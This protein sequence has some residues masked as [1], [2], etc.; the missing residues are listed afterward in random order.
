[1]P[2]ASYWHVLPFFFAIHEINQNPR[3]LPNI[4]LGY[5]IYENYLNERITYEAMI[6]LLSMGQKTVPNYR[7]GR[8]KGLLAVLEETD[9]ELFQYVAA[10]LGTY[11][12][13]Q[14]NYG[15]IS[16]IS[17]HKY[18]FPFS[19]RMGPRQEPPHLVIVKLLL[20]FQWTW[21][22]L[23]APDNENGEKFRKTF[24]PAA[25]KQGVCVAFS[26]SIPVL[27]LERKKD[28]LSYLRK[29]KVNAIVSQLDMSTVTTL[30]V[31]IRIMDRREKLAVGKV[32]I[33]T[34][35]SDLNA[36]WLYRIV[37]LQHKHAFL[38]FVIRTKTR[39][40]YD[41]AISDFFAFEMFAQSAFQCS[42][43]S[44]VLSRKVWERCTEKE[45][46]G[47]LPPDLVAKILSEDAYSIRNAVQ[48][49][50]RTLSAAY[51]SQLGQERRQVGHHPAPQPWQ[52]HPF[53]KIFQVSNFSADGGYLEKD[54]NPAASFDIIQ[55]AVLPNKSTSGVKVGSVE[56][57]ASSEVKISVDQNAII[58]PT[59]FN[60]KVPLSRCTESCHPG[61]T[62]LT[63]EGAPIC[64]Y[65]CSRCVEGTFSMQEDAAHCK[66]C[67]DDQH[68]N[69]KRDQCDP[70]V[71]SFLSYG[72]TLGLILAISAFILSLTTGFVLYIFIKYRETPIVK[73]NN[74]DLTYILLVSLLLSFL[75]SLL[76]IGHP[77]KI[78]CLLRQTTF[79]IVFSVAVSSLL[80]KTIMVVVA[81]L[82]TK[83]GSR[84]RKWLG[85]HLANSIVLSCSCVQIG[86]CIIW[87]GL[88]PPFPDVDMHSQPG[89]ILLQCNEGSVTM[90]YSALGY[91][92]FLAV[93][94][95]LVAFLARKLPGTFNEAKLITFSMLVF[96]SVWIS[97]VPT[98][99]STKGKYMVAVQI[100]SILS[101]SLGLLGCIFVPKC[102]IIILKPHMNM[103]EHLMMK[104]NE[105]G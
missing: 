84:M 81:F 30:G 8:Q 77:Q 88:S 18:H 15:V 39:M 21:I 43:S 68:S 98:Y 85:K 99:L 89:Q 76:F 104:K 78:T 41:R 12:I 103:K 64:C 36:R 55:W 48:A 61:Y 97:F 9:S 96:C 3:L 58:W 95:F 16:H 6:D 37:D 19:Y 69:K 101:S 74:R 38:S 10:M 42:Y 92:G 80:A 31:I 14:I 53:L 57:E 60:K 56:N 29:S 45:N 65:D 46:W 28:L 40:S 67:P 70:K 79:S 11:K 105:G 17:E 24:V 86:I 25:L 102:Y 27:N 75:T 51:T 72:E 5:N 54:G 7:C 62:K 34:A 94:C 2:R 20:H 59:S 47:I 50:S 35:L 4:T 71:I 90:F 49:V 44:S 32:W 83:P 66:R 93:V 52:L 33:I 1:M 73:A 22:C 23:L 87:L 63:R 13:P 100:F 26:E 91:M 82:A